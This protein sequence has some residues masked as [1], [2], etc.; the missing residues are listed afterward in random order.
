M[1]DTYDEDGEETSQLASATGEE[2]RQSICLH[3]QGLYWQVY[4]ALSLSPLHM[5][6]AS[7]PTGLAWIRQCR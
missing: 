7:S 2:S 5:P 1:I 6:A 4:M 3:S